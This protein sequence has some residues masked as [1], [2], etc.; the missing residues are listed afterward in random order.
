MKKLQNSLTSK[1]QTDLKCLSLCTSKKLNQNKSVVMKSWQTKNGS[2]VYLVSA[3]RSNVYLISTPT[4]NILVETGWKF[5]FSG[6][7]RNIISLGLTHPITHLIL[8]HTHFDHCFNAFMLRQQENCLI[9]AGVQEQ[10]FTLAGYTPIP[11]GTLPGTR[12]LAGLGTLI[13]RKWF[14]YPPFKPTCRSE[15]IPVFPTMA[16]P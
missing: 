2:K 8:T 5:T 3:G 6:L 9:V 4:S 13:G 12:L 10:K 15:K 7:R 14:G 1:G 11:G 16:M